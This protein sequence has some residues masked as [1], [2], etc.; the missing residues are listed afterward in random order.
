MTL[1]LYRGL[2]IFIFIVRCLG[3]IIDDSV[4]SPSHAAETLA[5][6][7][8]IMVGDS[9]M[10]Y[11]YLSLVY[12]IKF[13]VRLVDSYSQNFVR[14]KTW[15]NWPEFYAMTNKMLRPEEFCDCW[16]SEHFDYSQL[17]EN[18]FFEDK[19]KGIKIDFMFFNGAFL[20]GHWNSTADSDMLRMPLSEHIPVSWRT[21]LPRS[22][23]SFLKNR[24]DKEAYSVLVLNAG[25]H[26]H[27]FDNRSY[28]LKIA[29]R[30]SKHFSKV[31]WKTTSY[32]IPGGRPKEEPGQTGFSHDNIMC[33]I[34]TV[35][36]LDLSW[37]KNVTAEYFTDFLHYT[38]PV[39]NMINAQ[40]VD[41]LDRKKLSNEK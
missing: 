35:T 21:D 40:M 7:H 9:L 3:L 5:N 33:S 22:L 36:C 4:F 32:I 18:R 16:K 34:P 31:I 10:R 8:I 37:A 6:Q 38:A 23:N 20:Q 24:V 25:H 39:Y 2:C 41:L 11:Q 26:K 14:E 15:S 30:A 17:I 1:N 13:G 28:C 29:S 19:E 12:A 27:F